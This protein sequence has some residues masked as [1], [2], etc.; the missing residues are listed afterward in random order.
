MAHVDLNADV[1]EWEGESPA[2]AIDAALIPLVTSVNIACGAHAGSESVMVATVALAH[3]HGVAV[4]AHPSFDDREHFGR[5]EVAVTPAQ[6]DA[7]IR[8]QVGSLSGIAAAEG[9]TLHHVKPHGAL[10]NVAARNAE[11]ADAIASAVKAINPQLILVGLAGSQLI[12]AGARAGLKTASEAFA[13]RGY[14]ADGSLLSRGEAGA[15]IDDPATVAS[16]AVSMVRQG[17]V[18]A[19]DGTAVP[20]AAHT[21]CIHSDTPGAVDLAGQVRR[22]LQAAG[23]QLRAYL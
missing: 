15:I 14:R 6:L 8:D 20:I 7:L 4:G 5:R 13:D 11:L 18:V 16:R 22:A 3:R 12:A 17:I 19:V 9:V 1:G 2:A 10:Y 23:I 21:I